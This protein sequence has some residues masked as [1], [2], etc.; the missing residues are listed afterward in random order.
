M[1]CPICGSEAENRGDHDYGDK[2]RYECP[3]CGPFEISRT[4]LAMLKRR[5]SGTPNARARLSHALRL[6]PKREGEWIMVTSANLDE[7]VAKPLPDVDRQQSYLLLWLAAQLGED[8]LGSIRVC[9]TRAGGEASDALP[10]GNSDMG[11]VVPSEKLLKAVFK[12][13]M[14]K[15]REGSPTATR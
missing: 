12:A 9:C 10:D 13:M 15:M 11:Y 14:T 8:P 5:L 7:L 2:K 6:E 3:R 1:V 4:A